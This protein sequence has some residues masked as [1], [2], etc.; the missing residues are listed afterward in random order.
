MNILRIYGERPGDK[1]AGIFGWEIVLQATKEATKA[2]K[3][4]LQF[5]LYN[6]DKVKT[7]IPG[8]GQS[9]V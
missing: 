7:I 9:T 1:R 6:S 2:R 4:T 5:S 8:L 3:G